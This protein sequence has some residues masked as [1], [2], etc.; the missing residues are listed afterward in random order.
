MPVGQPK[1]ENTIGRKRGFANQSGGINLSD[2]NY[3]QNPPGFN[4]SFM[5]SALLV[6]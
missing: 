1:R 5:N 6:L 4:A 3:I 2:P